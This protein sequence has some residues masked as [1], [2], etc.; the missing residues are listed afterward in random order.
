MP[1]PAFTAIEATIAAKLRDGEV[2]GALKLFETAM[3][4]RAN[5][6]L[7]LLKMARML[8]ARRFAGEAA[9]LCR[10]ALALAPDDP[11]L[12][13][14][15]RK[16]LGS[17]I[18]GY[19]VTIVNDVRR[20]AAWRQALRAAVHPGSL[21][22]EIGTGA[23]AL[24]LLAA[25]AG[26]GTV[27]TCEPDP[28]IADAA[29]CIMERNGVADRVRVIE[30]PSNALT[31]DD[32]GGPAELLFCDIFADDF[33][34]FRP[35]E[36]LADA[37]RRLLKPGAPA[38]PE[39]AAVCV[40]LAHHPDVASATRVGVVRGLDLSEL[41]DTAWPELWL[42]VGDPNLILCSAPAV[43][44]TFDLT[45]ENSSE[46]KVEVELAQIGDAPVSGVIQWIGL[47]LGAGIVL[48]TRPEPHAIGFSGLVFHAFA[49]PALLAPGASL[50]VALS[51]ASGH[52]TISPLAAGRRRAR[53]GAEARRMLKRARSLVSRNAMREA[54]ALIR[55]AL[56]LAPEDFELP[57]RA[58]K[59]LGSRIPR[60][61]LPMI[62]DPARNAAWEDALRGAVLPG[63]R[64]LEI[65]TGAGVQ[66]MLAARAGAGEVVV[67][68]AD[69]LA[70]ETTQVGI[71]RNR[72]AG[73]IRVEGK[74]SREL[75][76][77]DLGG[78]V[79]LVCCD[80]FAD[81]KNGYRPLGMLADARRR[82]L[83]P[84]GRILPAAV[85][86]RI[87]LAHH[88]DAKRKT[89]VG[90]TLGFDLSPLQDLVWPREEVRLDD[91]GLCRRSGSCEVF[92]FGC[93]ADDYAREWR[94]DVP[95]TVAEGGLVSG[96]LQERRLEL[97][98]GLA[99][100][101]EPGL[102]T[103]APVGQFHYF[104]EPLILPQGAR[105]TVG[106]AFENGGFTFWPTGRINAP[107]RPS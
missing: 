81:T 82:L 27:A 59:I 93:A 1:D 88:K 101:S 43:A 77:D 50:R 98:P 71:A 33:M 86:V 49:E 104:P 19:H 69:P 99:L 32:I 44:L 61:H 54:A 73:Q 102:A 64:V 89:R 7:R 12:R 96:V 9:A 62:N 39:R 20:N 91:P 78:P 45:Q 92:R 21:V 10:R 97:A 28:L 17:G 80:V 37:R 18:A 84:G 51:Y 40:A 60:Y 52:L 6:P 2:A 35:L 3:Q 95:L 68:C 24:A 79:D 55:Q 57:L 76:L 36:L 31:L 26:A 58:R 41:S 11:E 106:I 63:S 15:A 42:P 66:A 48:E 4:G 83:A 85:A 47:D 75:T 72:L 23:G 65:G 22:L 46:G 103:S 16:I 74:P 94:S 8:A 90:R 29:R 53:R 5:D 87:A 100:D 13:T 34:S 107:Y 70:A 38:V 30:K 105:L 56:A 14:R 67:C 25:E